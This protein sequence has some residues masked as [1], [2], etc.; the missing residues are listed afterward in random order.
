VLFGEYKFSYVKHICTRHDGGD[1]EM[2]AKKLIGSITYIR[3]L[4]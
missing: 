3:G 1:P 4:R 2:L